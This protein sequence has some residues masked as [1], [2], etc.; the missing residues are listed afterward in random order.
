MVLKSHVKTQPAVVTLRAAVQ[1]SGT[2]Q[3]EVKEIGL[4]MEEQ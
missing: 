4:K 3:K 1:S 2:Q